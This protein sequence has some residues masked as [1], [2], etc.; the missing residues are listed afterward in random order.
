MKSNINI[1][2]IYK[3]YFDKHLKNHI[4][5]LTK[6]RDGTVS[7]YFNFLKKYMGYK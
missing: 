5:W 1:I 2:M 6:K 4:I 7:P 3:K